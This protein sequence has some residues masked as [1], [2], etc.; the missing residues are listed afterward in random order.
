MNVVS[1]HHQSINQ[2]VMENKF[3]VVQVNVKSHSF[4]N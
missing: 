4:T 2:S 1:L 3:M